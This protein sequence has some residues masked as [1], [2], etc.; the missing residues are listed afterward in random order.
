MGNRWYASIYPLFERDENGNKIIDPYFG[1]YKYDYGI[2]RGY[3]SLTN[4]VGFATYDRM[5]RTRHEVNS[6]FFLKADILKG[7][8]FET[9]IGGQFYSHNTDE[10]F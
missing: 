9:R 5:N 4:A 6:N 1:G 8:S 3:S 2:G 10:L 7:L